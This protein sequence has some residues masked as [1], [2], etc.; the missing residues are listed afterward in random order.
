MD[1]PHTLITCIVNKGAADEV[2]DAAREAG[3]TGGTILA[4]RGTGKEEDVKFFGVQLVPEKEMLMVLVGAG[5]T[6]KVLEAIRAVPCLAEP[7]AGIA[8]CIDVE[9]FMTLGG[10]LPV[11]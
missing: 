5:L 4:A 1:S 2:M 3:A 8:F 9:R 11:S 6:G 7:G 10:K